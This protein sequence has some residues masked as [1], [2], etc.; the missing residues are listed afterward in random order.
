MSLI[1]VNTMGHY[2]VEIINSN[3]SVF[4]KISAVE[5]VLDFF[6]GQVLPKVLSDL[7]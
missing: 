1:P 3:E 7:L 2:V 4:I 5:H 6:I